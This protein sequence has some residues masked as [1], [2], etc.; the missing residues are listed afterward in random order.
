MAALTDALDNMQLT[1]QWLGADIKPFDQHV[2][3]A[4]VAFTVQ[5]SSNPSLVRD[6]P[7]LAPKMLESVPA[8]SI[9]VNDTGNNLQMGCWGELTTRTAMQQGCRGVVIGGSLRDSYRVVHELHFPAFACF[10]C[11]LEAFGRTRISAYQVPVVINGI[12]VFPGDYIVGDMDGVVVIPQNAVADVLAQ[13]EVV[14]VREGN[15]RRNIADGLGSAAIFEK[16]GK[17]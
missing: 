14:V 7:G 6:G 5:W 11:P 10:T 17:M 13:A 15:I 16:Y 12:A 1:N 8:Y 2:H 9:A 3:V 4:G